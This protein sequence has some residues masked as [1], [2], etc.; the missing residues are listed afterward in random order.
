MERVELDARVM[1]SRRL[2]YT[3]EQI[4]AQLRKGD[5]Q[6]HPLPSAT[7][8]EVAKVCR[9][10]LK[11]L[12]EETAESADEMRQ[13]EHERL[14]GLVRKWQPIAES[15]DP[16]QTANAIAAARILLAVSKRRAELGGLDAPKQHEVRISGNILHELE[17]SEEDLER[18]MQA[19]LATGFGADEFVDSTAVEDPA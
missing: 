5:D 9:A 12:S 18:E 3:Y 10:V 16:A 19:R 13:L 1:K 8:T 11:R 15:T 17:A 7:A 2:G 14:D 4:A 6:Y